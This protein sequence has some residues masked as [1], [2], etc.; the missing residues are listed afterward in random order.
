MARAAT[1]NKGQS[2][3]PEYVVTFF[4]VVAAGVAMTTYIQ[5]S[6][7]A[8]MKD[9]RDY[10]IA[11]AGNE[12]DDACRAAAK[13]NGSGIPGE[14]EPYYGRVDSHITRNS[15]ANAALTG[16][17]NRWFYRNTGENTVIDSASEQLPPKDA[18]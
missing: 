14:Y 7:Q 18:Q 12:C 17:E 8:K 15:N 5:R 16:G 10:M 3:L 1:N 6:L 2:S 11:L 4:V 13:I 9:G